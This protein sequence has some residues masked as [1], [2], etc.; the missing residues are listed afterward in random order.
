MQNTAPVL[1]CTTVCKAVSVCSGNEANVDHGVLD[2]TSSTASGKEKNA[3]LPVGCLRGALVERATLWNL[4]REKGRWLV[5][6][7]VQHGGGRWRTFPVVVQGR[8]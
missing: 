7:K 5:M 1:V 3:L 2:R 8:A 6:V 4:R